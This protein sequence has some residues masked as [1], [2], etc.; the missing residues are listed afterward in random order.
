MPHH[1]PD[2]ISK[3]LQ[4]M[5]TLML[6]TLHSVDCFDLKRSG[7]NQCS[8]CGSVQIW[9]FYFKKFK[10]IYIE[11][12]KWPKMWEFFK[13]NLANSEATTKFCLSVR[14][15]K[16][17]CAECAGVPKL[18]DHKYSEAEHSYGCIFQDTLFWY[19]SKKMSQ[20]LR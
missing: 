4:I 12:K 15:E 20:N 7:D 1:L 10:N 16:L 14:Y 3:F 11:M 2:C 17:L 18:T 13:N 5:T 19:L 8:D 9:L 6:F